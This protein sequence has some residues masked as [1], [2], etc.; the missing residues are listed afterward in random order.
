MSDGI[1]NAQLDTIK[2]VAPHSARTEQP[3]RLQLVNGSYTLV[4]DEA[5]VAA[6]SAKAIGG[7]KVQQQKAKPFRFPAVQLRRKAVERTL[8]HTQHSDNGKTP[9]TAQHVQRAPQVEP[10]LQRIGTI[11]EVS[12]AKPSEGHQRQSDH[13]LHEA[14]AEC[15]AEPASQPDLA[16]Q[17]VLTPLSATVIEEL[18]HDPPANTRP[19][20]ALRTQRPAH[21]A[22]QPAIVPESAG[23]E[24][25]PNDKQPLAADSAV[26]AA[27]AAAESS[28][29]PGP[30]APASTAAAVAPAFSA[31]ECT[32]ESAR[33]VPPHVT[34][35][36]AASGPPRKQR[37]AGRNGP[38]ACAARGQTREPADGQQRVTSLSGAP[39]SLPCSN[40]SDSS[41]ADPMV[42]SSP[43]AEAG[44]KSKRADVADTATAGP[45]HAA[46]A[47]V[48]SRVGSRTDVAQPEPVPMPQTPPLMP[49]A[50]AS[51][52]DD[53]TSS[54]AAV[55][56]ASS[57]SACSTDLA[58]PD[59]DSQDPPNAAPA[60]E[61]V[62]NVR[63]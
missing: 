26:A 57:A 45:G 49:E 20:S 8:Q 33:T 30:S 50:A 60:Q 23:A 48:L 31:V 27:G 7:P 28:T 39:A 63:Q 11:V 5:S 9:T 2:A 1:Q 18:P 10:E 25:V 54:S 36:A 51:R 46:A 35:A 17:P 19:R 15:T 53:H 22:A 43:A 55:S 32:A 21:S 52:H 58:D 13:A 59:S 16:Q 24:P 4:S 3:A 47:C 61:Q 12:P 42:C 62:D 29:I 6:P 34:A 56:N 40:L 37:R 44:N 14:P 38:D 41:M